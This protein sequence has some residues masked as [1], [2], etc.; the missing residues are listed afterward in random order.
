MYLLFFIEGAKFLLDLLAS[1]L[2]GFCR[3]FQIGFL[4]LEQRHYR[5][6]DLLENP[7]GKSRWKC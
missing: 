7:R 3:R 1:L 5:G 4:C 2:D 6:S